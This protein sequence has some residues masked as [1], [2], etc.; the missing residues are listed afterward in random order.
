MSLVEVTVSIVGLCIILVLTG[1]GTPRPEV[2]QERGLDML[3]QFRSPADYE[4]T[5]KIWNQPPNTRGL[6]W[7]DETPCRFMMLYPPP[8]GD[9]EA[10]ISYVETVREEIIHCQGW[11]H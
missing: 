6:S 7:P 2:V 5:R 11:R 1:C 4:F 3:W 9:Y 8:P 10:A